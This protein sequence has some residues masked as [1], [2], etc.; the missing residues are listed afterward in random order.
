MSQR[1]RVGNTYH[2]K[3]RDRL[4]VVTHHDSAN[5]IWFR[6]VHGYDNGGVLGTTDW[7]EQQEYPEFLSCV[8][9]RD[10]PDDWD[11]KRGAVLERDDYTCQGC[12]SSNCELQVHHICP[13]GAGGSNALSNLIA[14][15]QECHGRV[16]GGVT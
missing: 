16:H 1:I 11:A 7:V 10:Y 13:L 8:E 2:H 9:M 6:G 14:L 15:C 5:Y 4:V 3:P 12:G